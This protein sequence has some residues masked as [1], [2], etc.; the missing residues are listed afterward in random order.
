METI[1]RAIFSK[2]SFEAMLLVAIGLIILL[3]IYTLWFGISL[4]YKSIQPFSFTVQ[5]QRFVS[6]IMGRKWN[7]KLKRQDFRKGRYLF[8][9]IK[10]LLNSLLRAVLAL[11]IL[12]FR[13]LY[14]ILFPQN[15]FWIVGMVTATTLLVGLFTY[16]F[17]GLRPYVIKQSPESTQAWQRMNQPLVITFDKPIKISDF[18]LNFAPELEGKV[19]FMPSFNSLPNLG[20]TRQIKFYPITTL[21]PDQNLVVY[22]VGLGNVSSLGG[23]HEQNLD[24]R[25]SELPQVKSVNIPDNAV[26]VST[27]PDIVFELSAADT[28][29]IEWNLEIQPPAEFSLERY[30]GNQ[31]KVTIPNPLKQTTAY[32]F[33]LNQA[34]AK[35]QIADL[36][37]VDTDNPLEFKLTKELKFTTVKAPLIKGISPQGQGA[38]PT[39]KIVIQFDVA[40]N[41][42]DVIRKF[43]FT[44]PVDGNFLW[45]E[46]KDVLEFTPDEPLKRDTTYAF[47]IEKGVLAAN[48]GVLEQAIHSEFHTVGAVKL[49]ST[50]P[51]N[52][53][54]GVDPSSWITIEF[55]QPI[56]PAS[57]EYFSVSPGV[58][59]KFIWENDRKLHYQTTKSLN[60]ST[61]YT[62]ALGAGLKAVHGDP[63]AANFTSSFTIRSN[64]IKLTVPFYNQ[65]E[66]YTCNVAA[67]RMALAYRGINLSES[68]IKA[69]IGIGQSLSGSSGGDPY[70]SWI[71]GHGTYWSAASPF[72]SRYRNNSVMR[73]WNVTALLNEVAAGNPVI[74][75]WQNGWSDWYTK[76]WTKPSGG[77]VQ[78]LN[79][80]HSEVVIGFKGSAANPSSIITHDPWR[81]VRTYT[82][83]GFDSVWSRSF[84]RTAIIVR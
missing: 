10:Y 6:Q 37:L 1:T 9:R 38:F 23:R 67:I 22:A 62:V 78:G 2:F 82:K 49:I 8:K 47:D 50:N 44:P 34:I 25:T 32:T 4:K 24:F 26:E 56:D 72:I 69:G 45:N 80:M 71:D 46:T 77:S 33:K 48:N 14:T 20:L 52:G 28:E 43:K 35:R 66:R 12:P 41:T 74:V 79:G 61:K 17:F 36:V 19:E 13:L 64:S 60:F 57:T 75:W 65:L 55:D 63:L 31:L 83:S 39:A 68:Q 54:T 29:A 53:A 58:E 84:G 15:K 3:F 81:G 76:T 7:K 73:N 21:A 59:G 42:E 40:M 16:H 27:L 11:L 70:S 30:K 18:K 5:L 51:K